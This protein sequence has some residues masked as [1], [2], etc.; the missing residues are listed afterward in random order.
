[1]DKA[2]LE[3]DPVLVARE[4]IGCQLVRE[5]KNG[6]IRVVLTET[7]A[8]KGAED[9]ASHACRAVTP[10][11]KLMFG[12]AG[13][14]YVYLIYGIHRCINVVAHE[15]G[16]VGAVLLR[17]ARPLEGVDLIRANRGNVPERNL[18]SGPGK[19]AQG[20]GIGL[21]LNGHDLLLN[22]D[23]ALSLERGKLDTGLIR[24]TP[25]IGIS[26]AVDLP[27]RFVAE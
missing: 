12:E 9:A 10:R 23:R 27:W 8:Y 7:E 16:G 4:L 19:L 15:P 24:A 25:R 17:G 11:N 21:E 1:M 18:L 20:L 6:L 3:R 5:T 26:K 14:L 13:M 2:F 22:P